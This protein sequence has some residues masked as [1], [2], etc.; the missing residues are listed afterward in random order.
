MNPHLLGDRPHQEGNRNHHAVAALDQHQRCFETTRRTALDQHGESGM[1]KRPRTSREFRIDTRPHNLQFVLRDWMRSSSDRDDKHYSR[2][3]ERGKPSL[4]TE[5]AE[6][7][8]WEERLF[9]YLHPIRP[10]PPLFVSGHELFGAP[11]AQHRRTGGL[12]VRPKAQRVPLHIG[13]SNTRTCES[14]RCLARTLLE[15]KCPPTMASDR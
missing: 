13:F 5:S 3:R 11:M 8:S 2:N 1:Q 10:V 15:L 7:A 14:H 6:N 9:D 4:D 12:K